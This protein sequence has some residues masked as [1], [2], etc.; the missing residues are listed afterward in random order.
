MGLCSQALSSAQIQLSVHKTSQYQNHLVPVSA[1]S[2]REGAGF[3]CGC[4]LG[5]RGH[6]EVR[7]LGGLEIGMKVD[8]VTMANLLE[9]G[10]PWVPEIHGMLL[11]GAGPCC[12][13]EPLPRAS[14]LR[15]SKATTG[16]GGQR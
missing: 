2:S 13:P 8:T 15:R 1:S 16:V 11:L 7:A 9:K 6:P 14:K 10:N 5:N 3:G 12:A 4:A